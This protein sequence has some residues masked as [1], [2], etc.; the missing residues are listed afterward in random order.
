MP[1]DRDLPVLK[2]PLTEAQDQLAAQIKKGQELLAV[3]D[4]AAPDR[5]D[6]EQRIYSWEKYNRTWLDVNLGGAAAREY[7]EPQ[8][9]LGSGYLRGRSE[10]D[11]AF[12]RLRANGELKPEHLKYPADDPDR[13]GSL[14]VRREFVHGIV[15]REVEQLE[16]ILGRL[17]L[18]APAPIAPAHPA[19]LSAGAVYNFH[20][21]ISGSSLAV[22]DNAVQNTTI[23]AIDAR[24]LRTIV[25]TVIQSLPSLSMDHELQR[26]A[27]HAASEALNEIKLPRTDRQRLHAAL[28]KLRLLLTRAGNQAAST[29]FGAAIDY[30][31]AKLG[32]PGPR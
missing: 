21:P 6:V 10:H 2:I 4:P 30:E 23:N 15:G 9:P 28:T 18:W 17:S 27:E 24:S 16:S 20:G 1:T 26:E 12:R 5:G 14:E 7:T 31:L 13:P 8:G 22:G 3:L 25:E 11:A 19:Q 29:V 32:L